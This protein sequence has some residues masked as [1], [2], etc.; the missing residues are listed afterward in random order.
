MIIAAGILA[1][2]VTFALFWL[3]EWA[4]SSTMKERAERDRLRVIGP[5]GLRRVIRQEDGKAL[6]YED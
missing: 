6:M 3:T 4:W 1:G 2:S 5:S